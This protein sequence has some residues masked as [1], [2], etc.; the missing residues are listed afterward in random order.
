MGLCTSQLQNNVF[1]V[2]KDLTN[3]KNMEYLSLVVKTKP[4]WAA[5]WEGGWVGRVAGWGGGG[6]EKTRLDTTPQ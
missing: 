3:M 4:S 6:V 2:N 5:P 1:G